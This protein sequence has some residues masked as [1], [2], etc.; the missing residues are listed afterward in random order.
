MR[1]R[2]GVGGPRYGISGHFIQGGGPLSLSLSAHTQHES[3]HN[4]LE[5]LT[6]CWRFVLGTG[7][8]GP[9]GQFW[10]HDILT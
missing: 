4:L 5:S 2:G 7:E 10:E 8:R 3:P 9:N 6:C 1:G